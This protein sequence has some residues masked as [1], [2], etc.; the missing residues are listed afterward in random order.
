MNKTLL[1]LICIFVAFTVSA[2]QTIKPFFGAGYG[3]EH[4]IGFRGITLNGE[5]DFGIT[6]HLEGTAGLSYFFSNSM[7]Q[8]TTA[9]NNGAYYRQFTTELKFQFH[10]GEEIGTGF[11]VSGGMGMRM[12]KTH[13][14]ESDHLLDGHMTEPVFMTETLRGSGLIFGVGY[15]F[16][17]NE[18]LTARVELNHYAIGTLNDMQNLS[19]KLGF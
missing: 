16:K 8:Y 2:Q 5:A 10:T 13:H 19:F 12:G 3:M 18:N 9:Q 15:G 7:P 1:T 4:R 17:L 6:T 14:F 11:L